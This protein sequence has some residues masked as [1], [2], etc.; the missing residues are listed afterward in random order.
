MNY[1]LVL[2]QLVF[3]L[4]QSKR[5]YKIASQYAEGVI[6]IRSLYLKKNRGQIIMFRNI[7]LS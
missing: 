7:I 1:K 4:K 6:L 2:L 5:E 3:L